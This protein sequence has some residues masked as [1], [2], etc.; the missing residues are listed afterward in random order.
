MKKEWLK[1]QLKNLALE[2]TREGLECESENGTEKCFW[3]HKHVCQYC[4]I[5]FRHGFGSHDRWKHHESVCEKNPDFGIADD[6]INNNT[7]VPTFS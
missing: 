1:P 2:S 5:D 7:P 6:V 3:I 4:G